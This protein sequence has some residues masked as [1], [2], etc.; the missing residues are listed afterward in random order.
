MR[1][2]KFLIG[3]VV[4]LIAILL[5]FLIPNGD[6]EIDPETGIVAQKV[7]TRIWADDIAKPVVTFPVTFYNPLKMKIFNDEIFVSE[8]ADMTLK[9]FSLDGKLINS[10]GNGIG[11]GPGE[12]T[13]LLD[14]TINGEDVWFLDHHSRQVY[15]FNLDGTFL[16]SFYYKQNFLRISTID[17]S[18]VLMNL[19]AENLFG[20]YSSTGEERRTFGAPVAKTTDNQ[21]SLTGDLYSNK[22]ILYF[23]PRYAGYLIRFEEDFNPVF[24]ELIDNMPFPTT[25]DINRRSAESGRVISSAPSQEYTINDISFDEGKIF[26]LIQE[27]RKGKSEDWIDEYVL[28]TGQYVRS[29][30]LPKEV[31]SAS[32][33]NKKVYTLQ[34]TSVVVYEIPD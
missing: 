32:V 11:R 31:H 16:S 13:F 3:S 9:R 21:L 18:L 2:I 17:S 22:G 23:Q 8:R 30:K 29:F 28:K 10:I 4:I 24:F 14:F 1:I 6:F 20:I 27:R 15:H 7:T 34:D 19:F 33:K 12:V 5:F 25:E 26:I